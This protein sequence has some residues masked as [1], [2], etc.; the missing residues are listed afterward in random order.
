[1]SFV[2][3]PIWLITR[4]R[5]TEER[6]IRDELEEDIERLLKYVGSDDPLRVLDIKYGIMSIYL[7]AER[8]GKVKTDEEGG[9]REVD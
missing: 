9:N 4:K 5:K 6:T 3:P 7:M 8:L 1:M 2:L